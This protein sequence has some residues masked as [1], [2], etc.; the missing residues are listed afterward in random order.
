MSTTRFLMRLLLG[1]RLPIT[2]GELR[3]R[4]PRAA[5][6]VRRDKFG[7]PHIDARSL[8][9]AAF[10]VGFCQ[11]QDRA[12]QLEVMW[13]LARGRMAEWVGPVALIADRVARRI[14]FRRSAEARLPTCAP[15]VRATLEAFAL[16][17]NAGATAGLPKKPHEFAI[18]GGEPSAWDAAD[19]LAVLS[20]Q[21]FMLPSNWDVELA[22][23]RILLGDGP[24][25]LRAL[26][27]AVCSAYQSA[28]V[29]ENEGENR[30][31]GLLSHTLT[32]SHPHT[33]LDAL[34][35]DLAALQAHLP[36]G[37]GSNNWVVSGARTASGKPILAN[38]PHLAPTCPPPWY[39]Q[40][41]R[42]PDWEVTGA[43]LAGTPV[44]SI[45]HNGFCAWG[46]TAGLI[47]NSDFFLETLSTDGRSS[48]EADG[49]F[50]PCEVVRET[51][52][53]KGQ[54]D[55]VEEVL[56]T[57]RGPVLSP[58]IKDV[59]VALSL[60][61]TWLAARPVDGFFGAPAA[62]SFEQFR[63]HF[64]HWPA[65]P[66][67]VVYADTEGNI[68]YQLVGE[69][70]VRT[71]GNGMLP[72]PADLSDSGWNGVVPFDRMPHLANPEAGFV[73][74][75]NDPPQWIVSSGQR[76]E[77]TGD[78]GSA[79]CSLPTDC[80]L[81]ADYIDD[82]RARRIREEL[83]RR[84]DGLTPADCTALQL[85]IQSLPWREM[86]DIVLSLVPESAE[87]RE[88]L[89]L[90][91]DWDG[92]VEADSPAAAVFQFFVAQMCVRV[93]RAKAPTAWPFALGAGRVGV[94]GGNLFA[95]RRVA[96]LSR[97][98]VEQP[99]GWFASW[100]SEMEAAL[101]HAVRELRKRGGPSSAYWAWGHLRMLRLEHPLFGNHKW[102]GPAFNRGP[103]PWGGDSNTVS[104]AGVKLSDPTEFTH[105]IANLRC[106][107]D[108]ADLAKSTF[109]LA[110]GQS[111]NPLS[112]HHADQFELWRV[113]ESVVVP[114]AQEEV[115]RAA[116]A[117]LRLLPG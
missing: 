52:R 80:W 23:L 117:T 45:G 64:A 98:L 65:L 86:R 103:V 102:L 107:F 36:R 105:N 72:R 24:E 51:I 6:T 106:V 12:G 78:A 9:D 84:P 115:I 15:E 94:V 4:G 1:K 95:D 93:A 20:L 8:E 67:N 116:T 60:S 73:A 104:Q 2:D 96:H 44:V 68:G 70:P 14:G 30:A 100:P 97:L 88:A 32:P 43:A 7:V 29:R 3:V 11:G 13:R 66:L 42:T 92:R 26:D 99:S 57:A 101:A 39:L 37:G 46:V 79:H 34:L 16:G 25:A 49:S 83:A 87:A 5:I 27:P 28:S 50:K 114:W 21:S 35:A 55:V 85:D 74:T 54:P 18:V 40:H 58:A 47:D 111:G 10:A 110:G 77:K 33:A 56:V 53:V 19:V 62:R 61:A 41:V 31:S 76:A 63:A 38:D 22:R 48:R 17:V 75:A 69:V 90:L 71:G 109:V 108:L 113:G 112:P 81:G 82:Y 91:A 89:R 59:P